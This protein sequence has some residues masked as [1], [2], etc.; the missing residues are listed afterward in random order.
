MALDAAV[1]AAT[2][3]VMATASAEAVTAVTCGLK[4]WAAKDGCAASATGGV[5]AADGCSSTAPCAGCCCR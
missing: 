1:M 4:A 3:R 5:A 2:E